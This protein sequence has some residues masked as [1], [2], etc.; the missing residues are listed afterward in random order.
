MSSLAGTKTSEDIK[1]DRK[2]F[3]IP[4]LLAAKEKF[5]ENIDAGRR[6]PCDEKV[7]II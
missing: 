7:I 3:Y 4:G 2:G 1:D 6:Q 5:K